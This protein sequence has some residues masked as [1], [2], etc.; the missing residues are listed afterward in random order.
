MK[1]IWRGAFNYGKFIKVEYTYASSKKQARMLMCR[2]LAK[3]DGVMPWETLALFPEG[4][5][6][7]EITL[8]TEFT[9]ADNG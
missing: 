6:N 5:D 2:R 7:Y 4:K 1:N 9:E 3:K 8:E